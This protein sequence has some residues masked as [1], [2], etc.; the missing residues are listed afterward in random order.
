MLR[1]AMGQRTMR[2]PVGV[3]GRPDLH[4]RPDF[5]RRAAHEESRELLTCEHLGLCDRRGRATRA[6]RSCKAPCSSVI[7]FFL[8]PSASSFLTMSSPA[9]LTLI[10]LSMSRILP[11]GPM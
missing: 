4:A 2:K 9:V 3:R 8:T 7:Y 11:S 5:T 10:F 1:D 6:V